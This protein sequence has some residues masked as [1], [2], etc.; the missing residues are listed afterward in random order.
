MWIDWPIYFV[1]TC[2]FGRRA[3]LASNEVAAI[4]VEE[5]CKA[6]GRHGWAIGRYVIMPEHVHFFSRAELDSKPLPIFMQKWKEWSSKRMARELNVAGRVWHEEF[7][8][9]VL[10]STES[11]SQKWDYVKENPVRAGLVKKSE[12]WPFQGEIESLAL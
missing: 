11:Y 4:L 1:T 10:R 2:I 12:D 9:H 3:I 7:F 8:D 6:H 5:W